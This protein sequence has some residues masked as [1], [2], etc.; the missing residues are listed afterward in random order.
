MDGSSRVLA[1]DGN[2]SSTI[3]TQHAEPV[4]GAPW[5]GAIIISARVKL[6]M[7]GNSNE[8]ALV[9]PR[10]RDVSNYY[11]VALV[12]TGVQIQTI[13]NGG[14]A[15]NTISTTTIAI[16]TS[17]DVQLRIDASGLL[18]AFLNGTMRGTFM[19]PNSLADGFAAVGTKSMLASF[20]N[21]VVSRP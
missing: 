8:A 9:C 6:L 1:Q 20:D 14:A 18:T 7:L 11:C 13:V 15:Q 5:S 19:P 17:Y 21:I 12:E 16:G 2:D 4:L 10:Y 3:R